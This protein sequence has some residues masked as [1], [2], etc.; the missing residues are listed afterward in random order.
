[1]VAAIMVGGLVLAAFGHALGAKG[2]HQRAADLA[3][4][5]DGRVMATAYPKPF[6]PGLP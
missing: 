3:A 4:I 5:S 2:R 6:E 1:V